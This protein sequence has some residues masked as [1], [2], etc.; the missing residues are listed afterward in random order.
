L[1][2]PLKGKDSSCS[3]EQELSQGKATEA[4]ARAASLFTRTF[5]RIEMARLLLARLMRLLA[6]N[7]HT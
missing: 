7:I 4:V 1:A 5:R 3:I 2:L 6:I